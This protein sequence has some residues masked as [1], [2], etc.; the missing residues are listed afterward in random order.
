[1][2][3]D[4]LVLLIKNIE[5]I[6]NDLDNDV[7]YYINEDIEEYDSR[8]GSS[9][10][11][12]NNELEKRKKGIVKIADKIITELRK[13]NFKKIEELIKKLFNYI[14]KDYY[15]STVD[16][17]KNF[18]NRNENIDLLMEQLKQILINIERFN[19]GKSLNET[20][21]TIP[22]KFKTNLFKITKDKIKQKKS[23]SID[24]YISTPSN[25]ENS[26]VELS[27][28]NFSVKKLKKYVSILLSFIKY[29]KNFSLFTEFI[30]SNVFNKKFLLLYNRIC[31]LLDKSKDTKI[32]SIYSKIKEIDIKTKITEFMNYI[33]YS[34]ARH[35][36]NFKNNV[37]SEFYIMTFKKKTLINI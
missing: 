33:E 22:K 12:I 11:K 3:E 28:L 6:F 5:E 25:D 32:T 15:K 4:N 2:S 23:T 29:E 31:K 34:K 21:H 27:N 8:K 10:S 9:K 24:T 1:M 7:I 20:Y 37:L 14:H 16:N 19:K 17:F 18:R 13:K 36:S 26:N 35:I 30:K